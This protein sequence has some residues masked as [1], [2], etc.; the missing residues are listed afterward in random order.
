MKTN[1]ETYSIDLQLEV[2]HMFESPYTSSKLVPSCRF[3]NLIWIILTI[4]RIQ[5]ISMKPLKH[6]S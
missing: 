4:Q 6:K 2:D 3:K 5:H 1:A